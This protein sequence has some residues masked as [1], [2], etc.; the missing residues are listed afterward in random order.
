MVAKVGGF[1]EL[2]RFRTAS[3]S[4]RI[5]SHL[6]FIIFHLLIVGH[7]TLTNE[8]FKWAMVNEK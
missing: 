4:D 6:S 1:C 2:N 8:S 7:G 5:I 3:G